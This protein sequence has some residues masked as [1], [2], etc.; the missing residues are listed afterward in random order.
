MPLLCI[1]III[2]RTETQNNDASYR[3]L[4]SVPSARRIEAMQE[5]KAW[6]DLI[7]GADRNLPAVALR[8]TAA[9]SV[10]HVSVRIID[11][12]LVKSVDTLRAVQLLYRSGLPIR[13]SQALIRMLFGKAAA[14]RYR[15][16][17]AGLRGR[18]CGGCT[19][20][21]RRDDASKDQPA[22]AVEVPRPRLGGRGA[23]ARK[24][25]KRRA[26]AFRE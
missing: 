10:E 26:A 24:N 14:D 23:F 25:A 15:V 4:R 20:S 19:Q 7:R 9:V 11:A 6:D 22:T 21:P 16:V 1:G 2:G 8:R 13:G 3:R 18:P 12:L 5:P 17:N